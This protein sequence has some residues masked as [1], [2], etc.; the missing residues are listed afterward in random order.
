MKKILLLLVITLLNSA[1][2]VNANVNPSNVDLKE[3][4]S[5]VYYESPQSKSSKKGKKKET[6]KEIKK[7]K[8]GKAKLCKG[9]EGDDDCELKTTNE[10]RYC[11]KHQSQ[12]QGKRVKCKGIDKESG[13]RCN[14]K[15]KYANG[16]CIDHQSQIKKSPKKGSKKISKKGPKKG[17]KKISKKGPQKGPKKGSPKGSKKGS[18]KKK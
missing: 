7:S 4:N 9:F 18:S 14:S 16:Y 11:D 15:T 2:I 5:D 12:V 13:D 1:A 10:N 17:P 8:S 6:P 3:S